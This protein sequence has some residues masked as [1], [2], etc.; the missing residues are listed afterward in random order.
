MFS[1]ANCL[2]ETKACFCCGVDTTTGVVTR[3]GRS[4]DTWVLSAVIKWDPFCLYGTWCK[5][6]VIWRD[7]SQKLCIAWVGNIMTPVFFFGWVTCFPS[8]VGK[9]AIWI[10]ILL[11]SVFETVFFPIALFSS[12]IPVQ[13]LTQQWKIT[14]FTITSRYIF[15]CLCFHCHVSFRG[16]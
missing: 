1:F 11:E 8:T 7:V 13:K 3:K 15:K 4:C 12:L 10:T 5:S 9:S 16:C 6:M 14:I 2:L